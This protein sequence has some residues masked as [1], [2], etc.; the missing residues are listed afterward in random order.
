MLN[1][2]CVCCTRLKERLIC[3]QWVCECGWFSITT[4][5]DGGRES[6]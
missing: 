5:Y 1:L 2:R 6:L 4:N 3:T